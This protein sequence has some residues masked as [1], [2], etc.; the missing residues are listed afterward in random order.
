MKL[1]PGLDGPSQGDLVRCSRCS[2][3]YYVTTNAV[4]GA[5]FI[6]LAPAANGCERSADAES[7]CC[8][9]CA[10]DAERYQGVTFSRPCCSG[11]PSAC[12]ICGGPTCQRCR[13]NVRA[14]SEQRKTGVVACRACDSQNLFAMGRPAV[15]LVF[16][17]D[18]E[19]SSVQSVWSTRAAAEAE[20]ERLQGLHN[21]YDHHV[22]GAILRSPEDAQR[23][24]AGPR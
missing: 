12:A 7:N 8:P 11:T 9:S 13:R 21:G 18:Y 20:L 15:F 2:A 23:E 24:N 14:T 5:A 3:A 22:E 4:V 17:D 1:T 19:W 16:Q 6:I 10:T